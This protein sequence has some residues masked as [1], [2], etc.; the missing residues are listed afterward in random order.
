MLVWVYRIS[1]T[2]SIMGSTAISYMILSNRRRKLARPKNRLMLMMSFFDVL[3]ST[4]YLISKVAMPSDSGIS[5]AIGNSATCMA[6]GICIWLGL[7]VSM[8]NSSLNLFYMLSIKYNMSP[9]H[10]SKNIEPYLHLIM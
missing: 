2:L 7:A 5:G 4:A 3:S 9:M 10:F 6:Q 8:Y 1:C